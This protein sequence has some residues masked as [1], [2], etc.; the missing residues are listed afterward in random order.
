MNTFI[1]GYRRR[2]RERDMLAQ[3][4]V[5]EVRRPWWQHEVRRAARD[6]VSDEVEAA[7][8]ALPEEFRA[9]VL[10]VDYDG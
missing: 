10:L 7:L 2:K 5:A 4:R 1:N 8:A 9:V 3:V 6:G